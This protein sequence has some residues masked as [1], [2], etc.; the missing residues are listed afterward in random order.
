MI[1]TRAIP[2]PLALDA[3]QQEIAESSISIAL[4]SISTS[5]S[6]LNFDFAAELSPAEVTELDSVLAAHTGVPLEEPAIIQEVNV[7]SQPAFADKVLPSGKKLFKR[8]HGVEIDINNETKAIEL[9]VPYDMCKITGVEILNASLGDKVDLKVLDTPAGTISGVANYM[10]NQF[11]YSVFM[12]P[13]YHKETSSYD[14]DLIKDMKLCL[15]VT[16][17]ENK[18]MYANF[19]LHEVV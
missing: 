12:R 19:I 13:D 17:T 9:V 14:A 5:G 8:V 18:K 6:D 2:D 3:L 7:G 11:G 15:E 1:Y 4:N 10:L 16:T